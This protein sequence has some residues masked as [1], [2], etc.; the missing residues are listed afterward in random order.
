MIGDERVLLQES[1]G[2]SEFSFWTSLI[3]NHVMMGKSHSLHSSV[4]SYL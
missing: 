1:E 4:S 3:I 2:G